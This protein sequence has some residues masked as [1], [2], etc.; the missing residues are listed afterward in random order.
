MSMRDPRHRIKWIVCPYC[1]IPHDGALNTDLEDGAPP[2]DGDVNICGKCV[3]VSIYDSTAQGGL[4]LP[5]PEETEAFSQEPE[6]VRAIQIAK[7][8]RWTI[9][10]GKAPVN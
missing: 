1:S 4:R 5:T 2:V 9:Q 6:I 8:A 10:R 3:H 7:Q